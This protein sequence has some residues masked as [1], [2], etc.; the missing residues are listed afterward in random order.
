MTKF[1]SRSP[2]AELE[3][4]AVPNSSI[5]LG[6]GGV[7]RVFEMGNPG[8]WCPL[9]SPSAPSLKSHREPP[10]GDPSPKTRVGGSDSVGPPGN[11]GPEMKARG[12]WGGPGS[13]VAALG[14]ELC[15]LAHSR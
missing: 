5:P 11:P 13:R 4:T 12:G 3:E 7:C 14:V 15:P 8:L 10:A 2:A 6:P 1:P 9:V